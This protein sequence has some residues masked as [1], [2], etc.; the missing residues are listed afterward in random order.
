LVT[1]INQIYIGICLQ[2]IKCMKGKE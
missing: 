1:N 2:E